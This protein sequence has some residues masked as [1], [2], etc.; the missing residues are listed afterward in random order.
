MGCMII[1]MFAFLSGGMHHE[2]MNSSRPREAVRRR[3]Q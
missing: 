3:R 2:D 1:S